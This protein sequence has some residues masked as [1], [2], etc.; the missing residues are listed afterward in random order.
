MVAAGLIRGFFVKF[1]IGAT[2]N[3]AFAL[4]SRTIGPLLISSVLI[5]LIPFLLYYYSVES[6]AGYVDEGFGSSSQNPL[7]GLPKVV[8]GIVINTVFT[9]VVVVILY[10]AHKGET[11]AIADLRKAIGNKFLQVLGASIAANV[12]IS[13][14]TLLLI[15][16][17]IIVGLMFCVAIPTSVIE[18]RGVGGSLTRSRDLT[19]GHRWSLLGYF[20]IIL[21]SL[22]AVAVLYFAGIDLTE[23]SDWPDIEPFVPVLSTMGEVI[24][25]VLLCVFTVAAYAMLRDLKEGHRPETVAEVFA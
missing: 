13:L 5:Y 18:N 20:P 10:R 17:G 12:L 7:V 4:L 3:K 14:A 9:I 21:V 1:S 16:P 24:F 25:S 2:L 8:L 15:I 22:L 6:P 19:R 23:W 11:I